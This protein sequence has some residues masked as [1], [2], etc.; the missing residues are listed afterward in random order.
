MT[1]RHPT[2]TGPTGCRL[3]VVPVLVWAGLP[4]A[5]LLAAGTMTIALTGGQRAGDWG[6]AAGVLLLVGV[7]CLVAARRP[8]NPVGWLLAAYGLGFEVSL[9]GEALASAVYLAGRDLPGAELAA[10]TI[11][12]NWTVGLCLLGLAF[13]HFPDGRLPSRGWRIV[14]WGQFAAITFLLA[15]AATL[16]P[17]RG[18]GFLE[19]DAGLPGDLPWALDAIGPHPAPGHHAVGPGVTGRALLAW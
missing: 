8:T 15:A 6:L 12:W 11:A 9:F 17:Q 4:I 3:L 13:L 5:L 14:R 7:G 10:W 16:W 2:H 19:M 1:G 18:A